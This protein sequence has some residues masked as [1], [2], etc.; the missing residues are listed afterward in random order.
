MFVYSGRVCHLG[1]LAVC[2]HKD[3]VISIA[4]ETKTLLTC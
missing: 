4:A 1:S 3:G 2:L